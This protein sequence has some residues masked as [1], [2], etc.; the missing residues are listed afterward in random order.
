MN[1]LLL[2]AG[3]SALVASFAAAQ[4]EPK[5]MTPARLVGIEVT[6]AEFDPSL[7]PGEDP[8][9]AGKLLE[10]LRA[11]E[12]Q[13]KVYSLWQVRLSALEN[14]LAT[15][16]WGEKVAV[17]SS[18]LS[19]EQM[20]QALRSG[21]SSVPGGSQGAVTYFREDMGTLVKATCRVDE[22]G[23][24]MIE[25]DVG[26]TRM[27]ADTD[28][29]LAPSDPNASVLLKP[30]TR[31]LKTTVSVADGQT[32]V[33]GGMLAKSGKQLRQELVLVTARVI[34]ATPVRMAAR[35]AIKPAEIKEESPDLFR[36]SAQRMV[37]AYDRNGDGVLDAA[38]I[39]TAP[40]LPRNADRDGN[41]LITLDEL[42]R[43]LSIQDPRE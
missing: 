27:V 13:E 3:A 12:S 37:A 23:L 1:R 10:A 19:P 4:E 2:F 31:T 22:G 34:N 9:A 35:E 38:E 16:H 36:R 33:L 20:L 29:K 30:L 8:T 42:S 26:Q 28:M 21:S 15:G 25:L 18:R 24:I 11:V 40:V 39:R 14:Q 6:L 7:W 43:S 17:P 32:V 41:G 5:P